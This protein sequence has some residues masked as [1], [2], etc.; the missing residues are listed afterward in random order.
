MTKKN[1]PPKANNGNVPVS[2][3]SEQLKLT[4]L[5]GCLYET[6]QINC[7]RCGNKCEVWKTGTQLCGDCKFENFCSLFK[8]CARLRRGG[9]SSITD[10]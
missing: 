3:R 4:S 5:A 10:H 6:A 9:R 7:E 1:L 2:G 8:N